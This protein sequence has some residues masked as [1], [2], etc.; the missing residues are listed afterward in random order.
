MGYPVL[1][2]GLV[3]APRG[4]GTMVAMMIVGRIIGRVD[5][6]LIIFVGLSL[7]AL[8]LWQMTGFSLQMDMAPIIWTGLLQGFGL[9]FVFVPL[10]T[11][12]FATLEPARR[13]EG[14]AIFSLL[15]NVGSSIGISVVE[16][17]LTEK[18]QILH[19]SLS[20]H[21]RHDNPLLHDPGTSRLYDLA[22]PSGL[23]ALNGLITR[24]AAMLA[25]LNDF[26]LMMLVCLVTL[27]LLLLLRK[28]TQKTQAV[29]M[30]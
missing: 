1:T 19:A 20:E 25:Y 7:T 15:R 12:T 2:A 14:S 30:E 29:V 8:S 6:R 21:V 17:M 3:L 11:I 10:S 28:P 24:Q 16:T 4:I 13:T 27:P 26:W 9:G 18:T 5:A 22:S 23:A